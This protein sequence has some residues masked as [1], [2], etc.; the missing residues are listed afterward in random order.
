M[1][2]IFLII[3]GAQNTDYDSL[4]FIK[5]ADEHGFVNNTPIGMGTD[6]LNC[7]LNILGVQKEN[8]PTGRAYLEALAANCN[9]CDNDIIFRCNG[10]TIK[11]NILTSSCTY[12]DVPNSSDKIEYI[13][14]G[15][16]KNLIIYKYAKNIINS[17]DDIVTFPPH[18]NIGKNV[19]D[20]LPKTENLEMQF[21]FRKL[22]NKHNLWVWG[23]SVRTNLP[24][25]YKLHNKTGAVVCKTEIVKGIAKAMDM[26]CP[27]IK[28]A[29]AEVD[30]DLK[31]KAKKTLELSLKYDFTMLHINGADEA[32]HRKDEKQK[33]EFI[34][35]IDNEV[36]SYLIKSLPQQTALIVT[37]DHA[38][39]V[40]TGEHKNE[41]VDYFI[42]NKNKECE[43]WLKR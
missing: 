20:I 28:N 9:V 19:N 40:K 37:S 25:F 3:D 21:L 6:S 2:V 22:I 5:N 17:I 35:K 4:S 31:E 26:Y 1:K 29:T 42:F 36:V 8:I 33:H 18:D 39:D 41:P 23:Q 34:K 10:V 30:T 7:I 43:K 13:P 32:S 27:D 12:R 16:Y 24:T 14:L 15:G 38:T 11:D